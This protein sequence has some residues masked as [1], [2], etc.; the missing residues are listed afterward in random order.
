MA[1][2]P[3]KVEGNE[4]V[5]RIKQRILSKPPSEA[6]FK[7]AGGADA[8]RGVQ[9]LHAGSK[10]FP[11]G[12]EVG[13][14][15]FLRRNDE[16]EL[17]PVYSRLDICA[18]EEA[19]LLSMAMGVAELTEKEK[20]EIEAYNERATHEVKTVGM[21]TTT[22]SRSERLGRILE[23][24]KDDPDIKNAILGAEMDRHEEPPQE[25][26]ADR[27]EPRSRGR[28]GGAAPAPTESASS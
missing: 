11:H 14:T 8:R 7:T 22:A 4:L 28:K 5:A 19:R 15:T 21:R 2:S 16:G 10:G 24:A 1:K 6:V 26:A 17:L 23:L 18:A 3:E 20:R 27:S 9:K 13:C 12:I 25:D